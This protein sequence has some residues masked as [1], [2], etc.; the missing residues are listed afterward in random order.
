MLPPISCQL[1]GGNIRYRTMAGIF[2]SYRREDSRGD[3]GRLFDRLKAHFR[4][5]HKLFKDVDSLRP[6]EDF[7]VWIR[8]TVP[9]CRVRFADYLP[10]S[11]TEPAASFSTL[12]RPTSNA[13]TFTN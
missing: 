5:E 9:S 2:I 11:S 4:G 8:E 3:A 10:A 1:S 7:P 6:G 13:G 12:L